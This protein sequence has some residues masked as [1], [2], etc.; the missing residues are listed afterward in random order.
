MTTLISSTKG[1]EQSDSDGDH[2]CIEHDQ[3]FIVNFGL[4]K[5]FA[6]L[7]PL[8]SVEKR[9]PVNPASFRSRQMG[10]FHCAGTIL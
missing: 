5:C 6:V 2:N 3:A 8:R 7:L 1:Y 4:A 9:L 10:C